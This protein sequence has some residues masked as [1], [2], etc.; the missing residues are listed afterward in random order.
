MSKTIDEKV[1]SMRFDNQQFE[2]GVKQ[3]QNSVQDLK[4]SLNFEDSGKG[5]SKLQGF[6]NTFS[7]MHM[8][9]GIQDVSKSF[10]A[11]GTIA[12]T[13]LERITN[14]A[15]DTARN[16]ANSLG[17]GIGGIKGGFSEYELEMN[18]VQTMLAN[19]QTQSDDTADSVGGLTGNLKEMVE[20]VWRGDYGNGQDRKNVLGQIYQTI[21][22]QVNGTAASVVQNGKTLKQAIDSIQDTTVSAGSNIGKSIDQA[23]QAAGNSVDKNLDKVES[24][25][26]ELNLYADKTVYS[27]SDMTSAIGQFMT[28]GVDLKTSTEDIQGLSNIGAAFGVDNMR[29]KN[30]FYQLSQAISAG[31]I[32]LMDWRSVINA[33]MSGPLFKNEII[34]TA[35]EMGAFAKA[36][37]TATKVQ[38]DFNGSLQDGWFTADVL[39]AS[40]A[41]F[42]AS[43]LADYLTKMT[44]LSGDSATAM[45]SMLKTMLDEGKPSAE[46]IKTINET[47]AA[48]NGT[49]KISTDEVGR[50][51]SQMETAQ[52]AAT[53]VK[54]FSQLIDTIKEAIGT[55]W[56]D[57]FKIVIGNFNEAKTLWTA[58][59]DKISPIMS[60]IAKS[61]NDTLIAW[62][63]AGGREA[64][65]NSISNAFKAL[66]SVMK[67]IKEAF[68]EIFKPYTGD[69]IAEFTKKIEVWTQGLE[70]NAKQQ[71]KIKEVAKMVFELLKAAIPLVTMK[72]KLQL[73]IA[74][75][76]MPIITGL[77]NGFV[78]LAEGLHKVGTSKGATSTMDNLSMSFD[79]FKMAFGGFTDK[80]KNSKFVSI[81]AKG[82]ESA[83][84]KL[85][86]TLTNLK[87]PTW[88]GVI[89]GLNKLRGNIVGV[90]KSINQFKQFKGLD[91]ISGAAVGIDK[92]ATSVDNGSVKL[93]NANALLS[94]TTP[95]DTKPVNKFGQVMHGLGGVLVS[96]ASI[97]SGTFKDAILWCKKN[98]DWDKVFHLAELA[99]VYKLLQTM[100]QFEGFASGFENMGKGVQ[101][102]L[103][104][105]GKGVKSYLKGRAFEEAGKGL[106][107]MAGAVAILAGSL[108]ALSMVKPENLVKGAIAIGVII[109][110]LVVLTKAVKAMSEAMSSDAFT[111]KNMLSITVVLIGIGLA[112]KELAKAIK[113]V[114]SSNPENLSAAIVAIT[115]TLGEM[116]GA[117]YIL[118]HTQ[119]SVEMTKSLGAFIAMAAGLKMMG[120][121]VKTF[122]D[123]DIKTVYTGLLRA[124]IALAM[125]S[126]ATKAIN[127]SAYMSI[128]SA[129]T[130]IAMTMSLMMMAHVIKQYAKIDFI[131]FYKGLIRA[132]IG[133]FALAKG[134]QAVALSLR[135]A[136]KGFG[137]DV[138]LSMVAMSIA[139]V[140][141]AH[142][143][144]IMNDLNIV[145]M[146]ASVAAISALI[147]E[148]ALS[149][150]SMTATRENSKEAAS[151]MK[152]MAHVLGTIGIVV[153]ALGLL[154]PKQ[155][156]QGVAAVSA[157]LIA[158]GASMKLMGGYQDAKAPLKTMAFVV[159]ELSG[160]IMLLSLLPVSETLIIAGSL[161]ALM[162]SLGASM[163]I[164]SGVK[165]EAGSIKM[166]ALMYL[167]LGALSGVLILLSKFGNSKDY[168][169]IAEGISILVVAL[170]GMTAAVAGISKLKT[171]EKDILSVVSLLGLMTGVV[172]VVGL[173]IAGISKLGDAKSYIPV[174]TSMAILMT[175]MLPLVVACGAIA[176]LMKGESLYVIV[177]A[178]GVLGAMVVLI[179]GMYG[180]LEALGWLSTA[181]KDKGGKR[182]QQ[183]LDIVDMLLSG[184]AKIFE[185]V[186]NIVVGGMSKRLVTFGKSIE[187]F[188]DCMEPFL[189]G[190]N[191]IDKGTLKGVKNLVSIM[192]SLSGANLKSSI[193]NFASSVITG[194]KGDPFGAIGKGMASFGKAIKQFD[195]NTKGINLAR[196]AVVSKGLG[197]LS[198]FINAVNDL[199][200]YNFV[201]LE[202]TGLGMAAFLD[203]GI[204]PMISALNKITDA[205]VEAASPRIELIGKM[206]SSLGKFGDLIPDTTSLKSKI[207]GKTEDWSTF[208]TELQS[209]ISSLETMVTSLTSDSNVT[210]DTCKQASDKLNEVANFV[211][212]LTRF[213]AI[214]PQKTSLKTIISGTTEDWKTFGDGLSSFVKSLV[215]II[216]KL[217]SSK[218]SAGNEIGGLTGA[219]VKEASDKLTSIG[220]FTTPLSNFAKLKSENFSFKGMWNGTHENWKEFGAELISFTNS[221]LDIVT[222]LTDVHK[223]SKGKKVGSVSQSQFDDA[224]TKLGTFGTLADPLKKLSALMTVVGSVKDKT[225]GNGSPETWASFGSELASFATSIADIANNAADLDPTG[226]INLN[227]ALGNFKNLADFAKIDSSNLTKI[228]DAINALGVDIGSFME[229]TKPDKDSS[230]AGTSTKAI[231]EMVTSLLTNLGNH[232]GDFHSTGESL[233]R[234]L[235]N[236]FKNG[237]K[238]D[239]TSTADELATTATSIITRACK[240]IH[241]SDAFDTMRS[242][243]VRLASNLKN[244]LKNG[245]AGDGK[246]NYDNMHT[247]GAHL[248]NGFIK[249]V[250]SKLKEAANAGDKLATTTK[251]ALQKALDIHSPSRVMYKLGVYTVGG[252]LKALSED[253]IFSD[254]RKKTKAIASAVVN[255][256]G[257][258]Q[259]GTSLLADA[260]SQMLN[261][262]LEVNPV[263][264]PILDLSNFQNG[265]NS[266]RSLL[267][268]SVTASMVGSL[269][270]SDGVGS[271]SSMDAVSND[272]H[273]VTQNINVTVNGAENPNEWGE[274]F[275][276]TIKREARMNA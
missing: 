185:H 24:A 156:L 113:I 219:K 149:I 141:L 139:L 23:A 76:L 121:A 90:Q 249:G 125:L 186:M 270:T 181:I 79:K 120:E 93:F 167:I 218:D 63:Q 162:L 39:N 157:I 62:K 138:L 119:N 57:S 257:A 27:F 97:V 17:I 168:V 211:D 137:K 2:R 26:G 195:K 192:V 45:S 46:V 155:A 146:A 153:A 245:Q 238:D 81:I 58:V 227:N 163:K 182:L 13:V 82:I 37:T 232:D 85:G 158:L 32:Q 95:P 262:N 205:E 16:M 126:K 123:M 151:A 209:F 229:N 71:E 172:A 189:K 87:F 244:G 201:T 19:M 231:N 6:I 52:D 188:W 88:D 178:V 22:D 187:S 61:R 66:L 96:I 169:P 51:V 223:N 142:S 239:K 47:L 263:V 80:V 12:H 165:V 5:L 21:Q 67:P 135:G 275:V 210:S 133:M 176:Y 177:A 254:I 104:N 115:I 130:I 11:M 124:G 117:M 260:L 271:T 237:K 235:I 20:S 33:N 197:N 217:T 72:F 132:S 83:F 199:A 54:T 64:A 65:I 116:I 127:S 106:M 101:K 198:G 134:M 107:F 243:G 248:S 207:F 34:R 91:S 56:S 110:G 78:K 148:I 15:M 18:S 77:A 255:G 180:F 14:S 128:S 28:A 266:I 103:T 194:S 208:G 173:V 7:L 203:L 109:G 233:A 145:H 44:D 175:A 40:I 49:L 43:G 140:A 98:L 253:S 99:T 226:I 160:M 100:D 122:G 42:T 36:G 184:M 108:I 220:G 8:D 252:Y 256:I 196:F 136:S 215:K 29:L 246:S 221:I 31:K 265:S 4:K 48:S 111:A 228:G 73:E 70:R 86:N 144:K 222:S 240:A 55:G 236:G 242:A 259:Q 59:N 272:N 276:K 273:S 92:F 212:P 166:V 68:F 94:K 241:K 129:G 154:N 213:V 1:V 164:L 30:T 102:F 191:K 147:W 171:N 206:A 152:G 234:N 200:G 202:L 269:S 10:T 9:H 112:M 35:E 179:G 53:K 204:Q 267:D 250:L 143:L 161:S 258:T 75:V 230:D 268:T 274:K 25:L 150:K 159:G 183:G 114:A 60:N 131:T 74:K 224:A 170:C 247:I 193:A 118:A 190:A 3:T 216:S 38:Q 251:T 89:G 174:A 225:I 264:K 261:S 69:T 105:F 84:T 214:I 41:K 50:L